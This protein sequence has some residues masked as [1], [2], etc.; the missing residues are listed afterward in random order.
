M[1]VSLL[2]YKHP[3]IKGPRTGVFAKIPHHLETYEKR[4]FETTYKAHYAQAFK[5]FKPK[6]IVDFINEK[7][8]CGNNSNVKAIDKIKIT[9]ELIGEKYKNFDEP[10]ENTAIQRSWEYKS[11]AAINHVEK[12]KTI[13]KENEKKEK[14]S[15]FN[16]ITNEILQA[17]P[18]SKVNLRFSENSN[19]LRYKRSDVNKSILK[20]YNLRGE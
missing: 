13:N 8:F 16:I 14:D 1:K 18:I 3:E 6:T 2:S 17:K 5:D 4:Y 9:T 20:P 19:I 15:C 11:N 7:A 10:K 12:V